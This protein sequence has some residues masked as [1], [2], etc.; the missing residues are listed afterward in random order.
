MEKKSLY[1]LVYL[2]FLA[3]GNVACLG[4]ALEE[5]Q[6][7]LPTY[8]GHH[9]QNMALQELGMQELKEDNRFL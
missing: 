9:E 7:E 1:F 8:R 6:K 2:E 5:N 4:Q 3:M